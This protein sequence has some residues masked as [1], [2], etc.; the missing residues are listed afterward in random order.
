MPDKRTTIRGEV[1]Q[2]FSRLN[3]RCF[4]SGTCTTSPAGHPEI[5]VKI[6]YDICDRPFKIN[7]ASIVP[8]KPSIGAHEFVDPRLD[9]YLLKRWPKCIR[10]IATIEAP[11]DDFS[12]TPCFKYVLWY[13]RTHLWARKDLGEY[14]GFFMQNIDQFATVTGYR[15]DYCNCQL[16]DI[17]GERRPSSTR[18]YKPTDVGDYI[19]PGLSFFPD[20]CG[21]DSV[22]EMVW[23]QIVPF[24]NRK[25]LPEDLTSL[26]Q[27]IDEINLHFNSYSEL[28]DAKLNLERGYIKG[29]IRAAAT[30]VEVILRYYCV[31][32]GIKYPDDKR[33]PFDQ[34]IETV[35]SD[36][37]KPSYKSADCNSLQRLLDLKH[38]ENSS[39]KG[40]CR[41]K[42]SSGNLVRIINRPQAMELVTAAENF[43]LWIDSIV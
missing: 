17:A 37:Q 33:L 29:V 18:F 43:T 41:Y 34:K 27:K 5:I 16:F 32:W 39:H 35:L 28:E 26:E 1:F 8:E 7:F 20:V 12:K 31:I 2:F 11:S 3:A 6:K 10:G 23:S 13:L 4:P 24:K 22:N 42:D 9:K 36:A 38:A 40:E 14:A 21:I 15:R 19:G 25:S 30:S